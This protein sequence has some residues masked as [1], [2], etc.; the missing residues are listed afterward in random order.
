LLSLGLDYTFDLGNGLYLDL[1]QLIRMV[2]DKPLGS[3][4]ADFYSALSL[5]YPLGIND[6]LTVILSFDWENRDLFSYLNW[7]RKY[8][9]WSFNIFGFWNPDRSGVGQG[10]LQEDFLAGKGLGLL[11][12]FDH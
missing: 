3:R 2:S 5:N 8:D 7:Q 6:S 10:G 4:E 9:K 12:V 1:E 11:V